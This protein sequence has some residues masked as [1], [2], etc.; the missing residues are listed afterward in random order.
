[1]KLS[2]NQNYIFEL[3]S[4][5]LTYY[6]HAMNAELL[7]AHA[8]NQIDCSITIFHKTWISCV[9]KLDFIEAYLVNAE[10]TVLVL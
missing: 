5:Q 3:I 6:I 4:S 1:M 2:S 10:A 9:I 8:V 7:F